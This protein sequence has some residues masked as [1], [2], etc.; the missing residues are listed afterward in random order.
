MKQYEQLARWMRGRRP[1][2]MRQMMTAGAGD[3]TGVTEGGVSKAIALM[4][5]NGYTIAHNSRREQYV[6]GVH[7]CTAWRIVAT[8]RLVAEP[9]LLTC[10][11]SSEWDKVWGIMNRR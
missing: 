8:Y 5:R 3:A 7:G 1:M 9:S 10:R 11:P 4:E 6:F 2:S